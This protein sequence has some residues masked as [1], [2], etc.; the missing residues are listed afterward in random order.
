MESSPRSFLG[1]I[2][3]CAGVVPFASRVRKGIRTSFA[4]PLY[5]LTG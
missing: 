5:V 3:D 4:L 1:M 2:S